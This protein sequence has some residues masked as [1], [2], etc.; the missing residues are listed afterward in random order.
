MEV[1]KGWRS[2]LD[3]LRASDTQQ[4]A[5]QGTA[6]L[7][8][9]VIEG[10]VA[11]AEDAE[12]A[13]AAIIGDLRNRGAFRVCFLWVLFEVARCVGLWAKADRGRD[14]PNVRAAVEREGR[15]ASV[16]ATGEGVFVKLMSDPEP[17][18]RSMASLVTGLSARDPTAAAHLLVEHERTETHPLAKACTR[19]AA[20]V[21]LARVG[22]EERPSALIEL[23]REYVRLG[24]SEDRGRLRRVVEGN[25]GASLPS[26]AC[27]VLGETVTQLTDPEGPFWPIELL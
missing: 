2:A 23:L 12:S 4:Q 3:R 10:G 15:V 18:V 20:L 9:E 5:L 11:V 14:T 7:I 17:E 25:S 13:A 16:L 27:E 6:E 24:T 19:Q 8:D 21:A 1:T 26:A 22:L